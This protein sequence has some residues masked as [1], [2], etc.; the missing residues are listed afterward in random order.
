[1]VKCLLVSRPS[2]QVC[3]ADEEAENRTQLKRNK[4]IFK[5]I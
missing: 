1:M 2:E 3:F 4:Y 5:I